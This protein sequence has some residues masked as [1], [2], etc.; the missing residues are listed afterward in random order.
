MNAFSVYIIFL[1]FSVSTLK[2]NLVKFGGFSLGNMKKMN[3][4]F[5]LSFILG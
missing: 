3:N 5:N 4:V 1:Y 2:S